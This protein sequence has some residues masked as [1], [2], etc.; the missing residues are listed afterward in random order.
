MTIDSNCIIIDSGFNYDK[1]SVTVF[2]VNESPDTVKLTLKA[3]MKDEKAHIYFLTFEE[4]PNGKTEY[5]S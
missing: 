3:S 2:G 4:D 5:E 1:G